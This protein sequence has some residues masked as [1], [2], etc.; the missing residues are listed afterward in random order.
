[1]NF[2]VKFRFLK[3]FNIY[4]I[5]KS[6]YKY[7]IYNFI[8]EEKFRIKN[9]IINYNIKK[10]INEKLNNENKLKT[11]LKNEEKNKEDKNIYCRNCYNIITNKDYQ[12]IVNGSFRHKFTNPAGIE[13]EIGC[14]S[15]ADGCIN[16]GRPT[17][18]YTWFKDYYWNYAICLKC[19]FH[20][21][22]YYQSCGHSFYGLILERM[23]FHN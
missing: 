8:I 20:L 19:H 9:K 5:K 16:V 1:M 7:L 12:I 21:G 15:K 2:F 17:Q 18:E 4:L 13:F 11:G 22:W 6:K 23:I 3:F 14:F 10:E